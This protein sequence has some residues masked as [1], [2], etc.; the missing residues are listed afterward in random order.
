MT[1]WMVFPRTSCALQPDPRMCADQSQVQSLLH[2]NDDNTQR[3]RPPT[4]S[5]V[6]MLVLLRKK[7]APRSETQSTKKTPVRSGPINHRTQVLIGKPVHVL[8]TLE[9]D[10]RCRHRGVQ[11]TSKMYIFVATP[12]EDDGRRRGILE[13]GSDQERSSLPQARLVP[14]S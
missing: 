11:K 9:D 3:D 6:L 10:P 8:E 5:P 7:Y 2:I 1:S 14:D 4:V 13:V 12:G